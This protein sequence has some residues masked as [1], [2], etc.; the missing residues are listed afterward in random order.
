MDRDFIEDHVFYLGEH[1]ITSLSGIRG[2]FKKYAFLLPV[3]R[4]CLLLFHLATNLSPWV[5]LSPTARQYPIPKSKHQCA[6]LPWLGPFIFEK[7]KNRSVFDSFSLDPTSITADHPKYTILASHVQLPVRG[8]KTISVMLIQKPV[9]R[10]DIRDWATS[11]QQQ[12][13]ETIQT[14]ELAPNEA[15]APRVKE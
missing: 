11:R 6:L 5:Y 12:Q 4:R 8:D 7:K 15:L 14:V 13:E 10:S 2:I 3:V 9:S 1:D